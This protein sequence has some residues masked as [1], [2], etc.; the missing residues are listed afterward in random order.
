[1]RCTSLYL[2]ALAVVAITI[3]AQAEFCPEALRFGSLTVS[4]TI[5][6]PGQSF[7]VRTNLTC[8]NQ[9]G[10]TPT[11]LDYW[12]NGVSRHNIGGPIL[13]ARRMYDKS[14]SPPVDEFTT[15]LPKWFYN[16]DAQ[17]SVQMNNLFARLGPTG[18]SIITAGG[19]EAG[20]T[21]TGI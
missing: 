13:L 21:I 8:A 19:I 2:T 17:Y 5:L 12:V 20:I 1:M 7:T 14:K 15:K 11:F 18:E 9:L 10:N 4:T 16:A 6:S 3:D